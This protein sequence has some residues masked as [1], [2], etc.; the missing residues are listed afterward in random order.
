MTTYFIQFSL[1][2]TPQHT[3]IHNYILHTIQSSDNTSR[4]CHPWLHTSYNS[5]F[6]Q[7]LNILSPMI[8]YFIQFSL[9][10]TPQHTVT[11][12]YILHIIQPSDN[13]STYCHPWLHTSY[14]SAFWQHLN[15]LSPMITYFIQFSLLTTPQHTV[16]HD[17]VLHTI[18]PSDNTSTYCHP[19]VHTSYNSAYWQYFTI[20]S[21]ISISCMPLLFLL[22]TE[23]FN[24]YCISMPNG[25]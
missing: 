21:T 12:D 22:L 19:C 8:T 20:L 18:Q 13:T 1:L 2:T 10:T 6:W 5:A 7:H 15:I 23:M 3:V 17:Y 11:H 24:C 16:T 14:N 4:H 25:T 9:L